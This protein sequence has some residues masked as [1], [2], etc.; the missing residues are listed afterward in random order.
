MSTQ[1]AT[2][3][4]LRTRQLIDAANQTMGSATAVRILPPGPLATPSRADVGSG[5]LPRVEGVSEEPYQVPLA[6]RRPSP[7]TA[8]PGRPGR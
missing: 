6:T 4:R 8:K 2:A 3:V 7:R 1:Y 5:T